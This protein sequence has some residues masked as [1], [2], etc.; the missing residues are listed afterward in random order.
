MHNNLA[1][2]FLVA[3][4]NGIQSH[5]QIASPVEKIATPSRDG[6]TE[7]R[8]LRRVMSHSRAT[9]HPVTRCR[10]LAIHHQPPISQCAD[11]HICIRSLGY[12]FYK[13]TYITR[14]NSNTKPE[15]REK[16]VCATYELEETG[17]VMVC[18]GYKRMELKKVS[19]G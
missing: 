14:I 2:L 13:D 12:R 4:L 6:Y 8:L 10:A 17:G 16:S 15:E 1:N 3:L 18:A 11:T 7:G 9:F 19:V 5:S